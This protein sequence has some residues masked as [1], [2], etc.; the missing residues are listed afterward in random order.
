M[1]HIEISNPGSYKAIELGCTRPVMDNSHGN[2]FMYMD[3]KCFWINSDCPLHGRKGN[4]EKAES[5]DVS[6]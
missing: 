1:E 6:D 3:E 5:G 2:G 4:T